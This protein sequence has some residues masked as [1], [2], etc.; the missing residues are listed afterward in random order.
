MHLV[1]LMPKTNVE[2]ECHPR[3]WFDGGNRSPLIIVEYCFSSLEVIVEVHQ[4]CALALR[5]FIRV[6]DA[7]VSVQSEPLT[8]V[9]TSIG[10]ILACTTHVEMCRDVGFYQVV[11]TLSGLTVNDLFI[12]EVTHLHELMSSDRGPLV[13]KLHGLMASVRVKC[14]LHDINRVCDYLITRWTN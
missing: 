4:V 2:E 13:D 7:C 10:C 9:V 12:V 3:F 5:V 6:R 8:V 11:Q 1:G 14:V